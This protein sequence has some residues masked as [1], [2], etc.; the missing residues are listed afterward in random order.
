[1]SDKE[2]VL[3]RGRIAHSLSRKQIQ[4]YSKGLLCFSRI[5]G[6]IVFLE[7]DTGYNHLSTHS[8]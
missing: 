8:I 7:E 4:I 6:A 1:M 3:I 2:F 5:T